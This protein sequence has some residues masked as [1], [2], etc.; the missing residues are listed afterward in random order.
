MTC[1]MAGQVSKKLV[2]HW[3]LS[4]SGNK[5]VKPLPLVLHDALL[6]IEGD[7]G[8]CYAHEPM[9]PSENSPEDP[10]P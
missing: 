3:R 9:I 8:L 2:I 10:Q 5:K 4:I 1:S 6:K 7:V